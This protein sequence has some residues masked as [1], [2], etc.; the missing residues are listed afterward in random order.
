MSRID[1][2]HHIFPPNLRKAE[3][4]DDLGWLTPPE[5]LP[6]TPEKCLD[7][8]DALNIST[9]ILSY[10]AGVP[11]IPPGPENRKEVRALNIFAKELCQKNPGRFG[12]FACLPDLRDVSGEDS[13]PMLIERIGQFRLQA[14]DVSEG[15]LDELRFATDQ[16]K[17][18]GISLSSS[19]GV[20]KEAGK[21]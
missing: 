19:Y 11:F 15:A 9:A 14:I 1:V 21:P 12:F 4:N 7:A 8:M 10:P 20:G 2:H 13:K 18:D 5:N 3:R 6:W 17:A 16:L